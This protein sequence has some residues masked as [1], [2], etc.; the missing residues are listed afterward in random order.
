[1]A[2]FNN[3]LDDVDAELKKRGHTMLRDVRQ[4]KEADVMVVWNEAEFTGARKFVKDAKKL[5]IP[6]ILVQHGGKEAI[7][8][9]FKGYSPYSEKL[10]C[11]VVCCWG[12]GEKKRLIKWGVPESKIVVTGTPILSYLKPRVPQDKKTVVFC[13]VHWCDGEVDENPCVAGVLRKL[14]NVNIITKLLVG[15]HE[16]S[17]YD[18]PVISKRGARGHLEAVADT[19]SKADVV[20][21]IIECT[22]GMLAQVLDIPVVIADTWIPKAYLGND[23]Y[24]NI[25]RVTSNSVTKVKIDKLNEAIMYAIKHPEHLRAERRKMA[26]EDEGCLIK[27]P[28]GNIVK[29]IE[30]YGKNHKRP[31]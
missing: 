28:L 22:F 1:M 3:L 27:D 24:K 9:G 13:P 6:T 15:E 20:V 5:G 17:W 4:L 25:K 16:P 30:D 29:V 11:D 2:H 21:E 18:N 26:V 31:L 12:E 23:E 19:L 7:R 8:S 14:E 10:L